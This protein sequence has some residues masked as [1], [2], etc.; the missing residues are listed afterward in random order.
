MHYQKT[1]NIEQ[2]K[3]ELYENGWTVVKNVFNQ[4][5]VNKLRKDA[6]SKNSIKTIDADILTNPKIGNIV[7]DH[8]IID[9][10]KNLIGGDL[11]Y[12]GDGRILIESINGRLGGSWHRDNSDREDFNG[13]D[14]KS[15]YDVVRVGI[16]LQDH[17]NHSEGI[18]FYS[19][20]NKR[21]I[22]EIPGSFVIV[23]NAPIEPGDILIWQLTCIHV[24]YPKRLRMIKGNVSIGRGSIRGFGNRYYI[25][26]FIYKRLP[27]FLT[28]KPGKERIIIQMVYG[29]AGSSHTDRYIEYCKA[30]SYAVNRWNNTKYS[31][32]LK[33]KIKKSGITFKDMSKYLNNDLIAKAGGHI[34]LP[35]KEDVRADD[36]IEAE[37]M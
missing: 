32:E 5:E 18:G 31:E 33:N 27:G 26:N 37:M 12:F 10:V 1:N 35:Y 8:R 11:I 23:D 9:I 36:K 25:N 15:D 28:N 14:W 16:Y 34:Q 30:R 17:I 3:T 6:K 2:L 21:E 20:S 19:G 13:P 24:G 4:D 7:Y 29:K 22:E